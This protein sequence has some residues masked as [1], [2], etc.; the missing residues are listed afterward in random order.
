MINSNTTG[1]AQLIGSDTELPID[2]TFTVVNGIP[3]L[4]QDIQQLILTNIGERLNRPTYGCMINSRIWENIDQTANQGV[5]DITDAINNFEPRVTLLGVT[6]T[7]YRNDGFVLFS[8]RF[9]VNAT[10][11][12]LN[13]VLP[14][15]SSSELLAQ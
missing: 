7:I 1:Q 8:V 5:L 9:I 6:S 12:P 3:L 15:R 10:N 4:L 11:E 14:F 2:G 13:L